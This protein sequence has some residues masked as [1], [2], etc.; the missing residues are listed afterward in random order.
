MHIHLDKEK[1]IGSGQCVLAAPEWFDQ[2]DNGIA[3]V[4]EGTN[5]EGAADEVGRA[6]Y[7]CP[8]RAISVDPE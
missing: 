7:T 1:C 6:A 2:D 4:L 5:S 3:V 8:A